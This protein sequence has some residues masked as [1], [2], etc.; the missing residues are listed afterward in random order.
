MTKEKCRN[1]LIELYLRLYLE[2]FDSKP[3]YWCWSGKCE[4][5]VIHKKKIEHLSLMDVIF[6]VIG[7]I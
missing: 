3:L 2:R 4:I 7:K 5:Q 1:K 6:G